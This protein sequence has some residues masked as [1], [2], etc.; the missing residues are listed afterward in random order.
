MEQHWHG[1]SELEQQQRELKGKLEELRALGLAPRTF[2][3]MQRSGGI[4]PTEAAKRK[5]VPLYRGLVR[6]FPDALIAVADLSQRAN[7]QHN[8]GQELHWAREKSTDQPDALLRH[9]FEIGSTDTDGVRHAAKV[10][11]RA[12]AILQLEI[13]KDRNATNQVKPG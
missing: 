6:Y 7:E 10:A 4:L 13:E 1:A 12:L 9:L 8:P 2:L 3:G 5:S 11:W